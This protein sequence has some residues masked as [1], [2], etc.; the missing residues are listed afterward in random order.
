MSFSILTFF[1]FFLLCTRSL[2]NLV[3]TDIVQQMYYLS[4]TTKKLASHPC[5]LFKTWQI[6]KR[7]SVPGSEQRITIYLNT[8]NIQVFGLYK[9]GHHLRRSFSDRVSELSKDVLVLCRESFPAHS[10]I[11]QPTQYLLKS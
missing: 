7:E 8:L 6:K 3:L 10:Q 11:S 2:I 4:T 1:L 9:I 5:C